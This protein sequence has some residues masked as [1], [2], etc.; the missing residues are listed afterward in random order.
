MIIFVF[1]D[2]FHSLFESDDE[3][4]SIVADECSPVYEENSEVE[5]SLK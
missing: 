3:D 1:I 4:F 5:P 2:F